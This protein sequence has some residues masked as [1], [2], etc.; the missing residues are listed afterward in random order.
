MPKLVDFEGI[1]TIE[2]PDDMGE[3]ELAEV[4]NQLSQGRTST[5]G[6]AFMR[7]GG[8]MMGNAVSGLARVAQAFPPP[9][10][11]P[12]TGQ[13]IQQVPEIP[14]EDEPV[15]QLG[16]NMA[17]GSRETFPVNPLYADEMGTAIASG[18]G[19]VVGL[20][21]SALAG[22]LAPVVS[23]AAYGLSSGEQGAQEA[24]Q[25]VDE[26]IAAALA[27]GDEEKA[28]RIAN[29]KPGI[30]K[31]A[32]AGFAVAGAATEGALGVAGK[33]TGL[34]KEGAKRGI[35]RNAVQ[36]LIYEGLQEGSEQALQN[37]TAKA[38][39]DEERD[40]TEGLGAATGA[41]GVV[42]ALFGSGTA[43]L[44][45]QQRKA[46]LDALRA[47][48][49][50]ARAPLNP[51][52]A[53]L[54]PLST[55]AV[56][57]TAV[58]AEDFL[59]GQLTPEMLG[60]EQPAEA[61]A[62][63]VE[64]VA[65]VAPAATTTAEYETGPVV[66]QPMEAAPVAV[67]EPVVAP[68]VAAEEPAVVTAG[69][70]SVA[71]TPEPPE[72]IAAQLALTADPESSKAVTLVT[73][74]EDIQE[75]PE[76]LVGMDTPQG[77]AIYNPQKITEAEVEAAAA[78]DV[79]DPGPL[80]MGVAVPQSDVA[81]TTA[82]PDGTPNV[83]AE[84]ATPETVD[85]AVQAQQAA[86]PGGT[87]EV[88]PAQ[89]VVQ[90]RVDGARKPR[91]L[92]GTTV[93]IPDD[94]DAFSKLYRETLK[95]L[96]S[97]TPE[98]AG[99]KV[100]AERMAD[101]QDAN[102]EFVARIDAE[103]EALP[104]PQ[105]K[106]LEQMTPDEIV[107]EAVFKKD[108]IRWGVK[109]DG[110]DVES[111]PTRYKDAEGNERTATVGSIRFKT[112]AEA[113][114]VL[115]S[116]HQRHIT[117]RI[118]KGDPVS[119]SAVA[120]YGIKAPEGWTQRG[121][122]WYP[123][124]P[125]AAVAPATAEESPTPQLPVTEA[126]VPAP[127]I[128][129]P[130]TP[131]AS[132]VV[133]QDIAPVAAEQVLPEKQKQSTPPLA[134]QAQKKFL[135]AEI[136][137]AITD[138]PEQP[139][140]VT[141][142]K[143]D[144]Q[145]AGAV[146]KTAAERNAVLA[147]LYAKYGVDPEAKK[148]VE[149][150]DQAMLKRDFEQTETITIDV[151]GDGSFTIRNTKSALKDFQKRAQKFPTTGPKPVA[152]KGIRTTPDKPVALGSPTPE[153][154]VK[155]LAP[156]ASTD[157]TRPAI[158][159]IWTDGTQSVATDG[160]RMMIVDKGLGGSKKTPV[161][162]TTDGKKAN[163]DLQYP[164]WKQVLPSEPV[165]TIKNL[166]VERLWTVLRQALE[167]A[168]TIKGD[169]SVKLLLNTDGSIGVSTISPEGEYIHNVGPDAVVLGAFNP[170]YLLGGLES[171]RRMGATNVAL[172]YIDDVA[173][174]SLRSEIAR[175]VV[176]PMRS[177]SERD[178][179]GN[180]ATAAKVR[181]IL[182]S[183]TATKNPVVTDAIEAKLNA[184][185]EA[186]NP[187]GKT[188]EF[189]AGVSYALANTA[190]KIAK[191]VYVNTRDLAQAVRA[192][193]NHMRDNAVGPF[194]ESTAEV[195]VRE[196]LLNDQNVI[197]PAAA[198]GARTQE[199][200][201]RFTGVITKDTDK[202]W[203]AAADEWLSQFN[204]DLERAT[205]ETIGGNLPDDVRQY[206]LT[207]LIELTNE[208]IRTA[209]NP[210]DQMQA[211]RLQARQADVMRD[212]GAIAGKVLAARNLAMQRIE[213]LMPVLLYRNLVRAIQQRRIPF[214]EVTSDSIR[215][216]L[217]D[218]GK[219]AVNEVKEAMSKADAVVQRVLKQARQDYGETWR[220][221]LTASIEAQGNHRVEIYRRIKAHPEL[222][223]LDQAGAIELTNLLADAWERERM[224][225][226]R[227]EFR[228]K[229]ALPNVKEGDIKKLQTALPDIV[230][231]ANLGLLDNGAFRNALAKQYGVATIDDA[232][233]KRLNELAQNA[234]KA[235][236]GVMRN[237]IL[238]QMSDLIQTV[239]GVSK[240]DILRDYWYA[241][242]LSG[243][244]TQVDNGMAIMNGA[245]TSALAAIRTPAA[246]GHIGRAYMAGFGEA[247]K[248]FV[249]ILKGERWRMAN[250]DIDRPATTLDS[251][252][253]NPNPF[254]KALG[255]FAVVGRLINALDHLNALST[256]QAML[257]WSIHRATDGEARAMM[258]P[259]PTD[260][261][262]ARARAVSEGT[263]AGL[264]QK[265]TREI[266]EDRIAPELVLSATELGRQVSYQNEPYGFLA[267]FY[268]FVRGLENLPRIGKFA[269]IVSGT[270]FARY[271]VNYS[272]DLLNYVAPV[273]LYRW[274]ESAPVRSGESKLNFTPEMRDLIL[275]KAALG[276]VAAAAAAATFL[277]GDDDERKRAIDITG[278]FKSLDPAKRNQLLA[279]GRVP[280]S[281][282]F[283]DQYVSYRQTP[284]AGILGSVGEMRDRQLYQPEE[285]SKESAANHII[286]GAIAGM[287]IVRDS[288]AISG[289]MDLIGVANS[290]KY[291]V[292]GIADKS[293]P[294][295]AAR[296]MGSLIPNVAK[297][298]D[299][300]TD[301]SLYRGNAPMEYFLQ[302]MPVARAKVG[303]GP[304]LNIFG[305]PVRAE[306]YPW[307]RWT[308]NRETTPE[309]T[310][311]G[312]LASKGVFLPQPTDFVVTNL[313]GTRRPATEKEKYAYQKR[314]GQA[315]K[316]FV[317]E[318]GG[319]LNSMNPFDATEFIKQETEAIRS[320]I[321]GDLQP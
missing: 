163:T 44:G 265:R 82:A 226:F 2:V 14:L 295:F 92:S 111:G 192:A 190:L 101:L 41:G 125:A 271:A 290:Y 243:I 238:A 304:L 79:F 32:F 233:G 235:P 228:K 38:L 317:R 31:K 17:A 300:W 108:G 172:D 154:V 303:E 313:D 285:W 199:S 210:V 149:L 71:P 143:A 137:K 168:E 321:R 130:V 289:L 123:P 87:T 161:L 25:Y 217:G 77:V 129:A 282:R 119:V 59:S 135:L 294:K 281:I 47:E 297:E 66:G 115:K 9:R 144:I 302:Q 112:K 279:E 146:F 102:P 320:E 250:I 315:Y 307:S 173:P 305:E 246:V 206:A 7:A 162:V 93:A 51:V 86:V 314:V 196:M 98:Q 48:R 308:N 148:S 251:L 78:G 276:T 222:Q 157:S 223:N 136:G 8:E 227:A 83:V 311:V 171:M 70:A 6:G 197:P 232:T 50:A 116:A 21:P 213:H 156:V 39:Y 288:S 309:W 158:N 122:L 293:V 36:G 30:V 68:A 178:D 267:H 236:R 275:M 242:M 284:L 69:T 22:P 184:A 142:A 134:P 260:I 10:N 88:V 189:V 245:L 4:Y 113:M 109:F 244:R 193:I 183:P 117:S 212:S 262:D 224:K 107:S 104:A 63:V 128:P 166:N 269:R 249:P 187:R 292:A 203:S 110:R 28:Q 254:A 55:G 204:G 19:S 89:Q 266:L 287:F 139:T 94:Y 97:Y 274:Y 273:A 90:E 318:N 216:W 65:P 180:A 16:Q 147:E 256:R 114:A 176:M 298:A 13:P 195:R 211:L 34:V 319:E 177:G 100:Y 23:G 259:S 124:S 57:K 186:T 43:G 3:G 35:V 220:A 201:G 270:A 145:R 64:P 182:M 96:L 261:A 141:D 33:A 280:Y 200:E 296:M 133:G 73:P 283:G 24:A 46:R 252:L 160:R 170:E 54:A 179:T 169:P 72:V 164:N 67:E 218:A 316:Q 132:K 75:I 255:S 277:E 81:V 131:E 121:D 301:P 264:V 299:A 52:D 229:V 175:F 99:S 257:A 272:N 209:R 286:N 198:P 76:G 118:S 80:G 91:V 95:R 120:A 194:D 234:Q 106:P 27:T 278:S 11:N 205:T 165:G 74:G 312:N 40:I 248:D 105:R 306:R 291:D 231:Q 85:A 191:A 188:F 126:P 230:K 219:Q 29:M 56:A 12:V 181:E 18:A 240:G 221:I 253:R 42:G 241:A 151:P 60:E 1:G 237:R 53:A 138:A 61:T 152:P 15:Y 247:A 239:G 127:P 185:I 167:V 268:N 49:A 258:I 215:A 5:A 174:I 150:L 26:Q 20:L 103:T 310:T 155:A 45:M 214:P 58:D 153:N 37:A 225:L 202:Q 62:A 159:F 207:K 208:R 140:V 263:P 84:L